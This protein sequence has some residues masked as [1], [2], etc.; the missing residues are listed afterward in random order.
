MKK[1]MLFITVAFSMGI[2]RGQQNTFSKVLYDS[3][4]DITVNASVPAYDQGYLIAGA[5]S[6]YLDINNKI[7]RGLIIK[8]DN[9]GDFLW[10]ETIGDTITSFNKPFSFNSIDYT[11]D[12][13][14]IM[15]GN[16]SGLGVCIKLN[17][18]G[19]TIWTTTIE[20]EGNLELNSIC[21]T[22]D[23]G[24]IVAGTTDEK[25]FVAR[26][27][28]TGAIEWSKMYFNSN[29]N[30]G[31][32]KV[33][34][35]S[36]SG[37]MILGNSNNYWVNDKC[38]LIKLSNTGNIIWVKTYSLNNQLGEDYLVF[39]DFV[40]SENGAV[41]FASISNNPALIQVDD[42][43]SILWEKTY[44]DG[45]A[46]HFKEGKS[47]DY[48]DT[49]PKLTVLKSGD[50]VFTS[51]FPDYTRANY[52]IKTDTTGNPVFSSILEIA[53]VD[54]HETGNKELL[55]IGNGPVLGG[56]KSREERNPEIGFIQT[57]SLGNGELYSECVRSGETIRINYD[58][59]TVEPLT[60]SVEEAGENNNALFDIASLSVLQRNGCV[61]KISGIAENNNN[62]PLKVYPNPTA[63]RVT[64]E[65]TD[66]KTGNIQI[67]NALGKN[68]VNRKLKNRKTTVDLSEFG[69]GVYY[70]RFTG[71]DGRSV[72]GKVVVE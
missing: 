54:V 38:F 37:Y 32:Y 33:I 14:Y 15:C 60:L 25:L 56:K 42:S 6:K 45:Y 34:Q 7:N 48:M 9:N 20:T 21:Q 70:Y 23:S 27:S 31:G 63:G 39:N 10:A 61:G 69:A 58:T 30:I 68:I 11:K 24:Y 35:N 44:G 43:G 13:C 62:K 5:F 55:I 29:I 17:P 67:F 47:F 50:Y 26:L 66:K 46:R 72:G 51:G 64:F 22:Y 57:D 3:L 71:K 12:S 59:I 65:S 53:S 36:D 16:H 28:P 4:F 8:I 49:K 18:G 52:L 1:L 19:D 41:I 2:A 40:L